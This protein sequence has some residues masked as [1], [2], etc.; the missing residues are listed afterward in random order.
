ME[1]IMLRS[2]SELEG[3]VELVFG[4]EKGEQRD[5]AP[6][7]FGKWAFASVRQ[8]TTSRSC[9]IAAIFGFVLLVSAVLVPVS[10][11]T[12]HKSAALS[13]R[14]PP[15][16][17]P[18]PQPVYGFIRAEGKSI[19]D[20]N[21]NEFILRGMGFGGWMLQEPYM[22]LVSDSA[23]GGQHD[24]FN[25]IE[26]LLGSENL[27]T[28]RQAWLDNYC[29][30]AD[31]LALKEA[32][33]N[34][35]RVVLHYNLFTL[36]IEEEPIRG[37]D[38]WLSN[39]FDRLDRLLDWCRTEEVYLILDL[40]SAPG[41][42][43]RDAGISDY[44]D[45]KPS[46]WE[47][48]ENIRKTVALWEQF[49]NRY[50]DEQWIGGYDLLNEPNWNFVEGHPNG[51][52][53]VANAPLKDFYDQ[54]IASIRAVDTNHLIIIE[55]NCWGNNHNGLWPIDDTNVAM[56]FHRYW[57]ANTVDSIQQFLDWRDQYNIPLW[58]GESGENNDQWYTEAV[59]LLEANSIGWAWWTWKKME[60]SSGSYSIKKPDGYQT[61][62]DF[63]ASSSTG[64]QKPDSNF[65]FQVM[66]ALADSALLKNTIRNDGAI[67]A[68]S[69]VRGC[70]DHAEVFVDSITSVR[71]QAEDCC[72]MIGFTSEITSD[73]GGGFDVGWTDAGDWL[74]FKI[75]VPIHARYTVR[76]RVSSLVGMGGFVLKK[77]KTQ[78]LLGEMKTL[79]VTGDW[80]AWDTVSHEVMLAVGT[81]TISIEATEMGW[82]LN[83][84]EMQYAGPI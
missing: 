53:E 80:Q 5:T 4:N 79:P 12:K 83:W 36:P 34:S 40:H 26:G 46:L 67:L 45:T 33:F 60:S 71:I 27:E 78:T 42:Q 50:R 69:S 38:T 52:S 41:G 64:A 32:G 7:I 10:L 70:E 77:Y 6:L 48:S 51:C 23:P 13:P 54:A 20:P 61:L 58:M 1:M 39:G 82:N 47:D 73:D 56:S 74:A 81:Q 24:I 25:N 30:E 8:C 59:Q 14:A 11:S 35:L 16:T 62:V 76:Y 9:C 21:G 17:S 2:G 15:V 57:V 28:Y 19:V 84:F 44:D 29:T 31:V 75:S 37:Q 22:M 66:M 72:D 65:T 18:Q 43:G 68:L 55:G 49:A 63:W 3:D